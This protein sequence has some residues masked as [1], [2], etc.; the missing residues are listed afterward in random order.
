MRRSFL[1]LVPI[2][3]FANCKKNISE[4]AVTSMYFPPAPATP[5]EMVTPSSLGWNENEL[6]NLYSFLQ[7][8]NTKAFIIL[9]DGRIA[10]ERY[11]GTFKADSNWYW[12]SAGK[13]DDW[14]LLLA[15]P[16]RKVSLIL[17]TKLH[18]TS[19]QAGHHFRWLRK[20]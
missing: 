12:A 10:A 5:W 14:L 18:N 3:L 16:N 8:K 7:Q 1:L 11:F 19:E 2:F 13:N 4:S 17:I 9:K 20:I 15:L 6:T